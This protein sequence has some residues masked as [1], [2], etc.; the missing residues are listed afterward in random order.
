M[1]AKVSDSL[2]YLTRSYGRVKSETLFEF[3][4]KKAVER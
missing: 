4:R 1:G 3:G 2:P